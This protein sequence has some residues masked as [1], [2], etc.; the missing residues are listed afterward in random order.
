MSSGEPAAI[1]PW[2]YP[3]HPDGANLPV[4]KYRPGSQGA[5]IRAL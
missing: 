2:T 4:E 5:N 1:G 3:K